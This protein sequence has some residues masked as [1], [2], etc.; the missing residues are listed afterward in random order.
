M[1]D[2][3][4]FEVLIPE[5]SPVIYS[6]PVPLVLASACTQSSASMAKGP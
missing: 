3:L 1:G 2:L 4:S 6:K 5:C